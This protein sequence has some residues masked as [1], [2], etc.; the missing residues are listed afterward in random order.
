MSWRDKGLYIGVEK[1]EAISV[2]RVIAILRPI[3]G[4]RVE[5]QEEVVMSLVEWGSSN[6]GPKRLGSGSR[7]KRRLNYVVPPKNATR[8][9]AS[10]QPHPSRLRYAHPGRPAVE[11]VHSWPKEFK[12]TKTDAE[13]GRPLPRS[14]QPWGL[15]SINREPDRAS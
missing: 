9:L 8:T 4:A 10:P 11:N 1:P 2:P 14:K 6:A 7:L 12:T 15:T 5:L 13:E 3:F